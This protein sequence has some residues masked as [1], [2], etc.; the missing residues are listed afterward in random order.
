MRRSG[1]ANPA[2]SCVDGAALGDTSTMPVPKAF[3]VTD[4]AVMAGTGVA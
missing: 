3:Q 2:R 4:K 1:L